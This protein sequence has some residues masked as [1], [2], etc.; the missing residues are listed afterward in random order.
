MF[1]RLLDRLVM[2]R[3]EVDVIA[4]PSTF[5]CRDCG[6]VVE[7]WRDTKLFVLGDPRMCRCLRNSEDQVQRINTLRY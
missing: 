3:S 7:V 6:L 2:S 4:G 5:T 1:R